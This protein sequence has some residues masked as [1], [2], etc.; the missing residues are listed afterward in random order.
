MHSGTEDVITADAAVTLDGLFRQ[1]LHRSPDRAAYRSYDKEAKQ[2]RDVTWA[3]TAAEVARWQESL[4]KEGLAPGDRVALSVRNCWEWVL[5]EQAA[6]G[7]GLVVVPLYTDDRPDN[8]AYILRD[9]AVKVLMVG[10]AG[11]WRRLAPAMQGIEQLRRVLIL[12]CERRPAPS[13]ADE[14]VICVREWLASGEYALRERHGPA[15]DLATIVYTSGTTGRPKGVMLSHHNILAIAHSALAS[16]DVYLE[17]VLLS[18]LPLSHS[19]ERTVGYYLPMMAGATVAYARSIQQLSDDLRQVR[20][21]MLIAV[22]RIF[23]RIY[24]RIQEQL[25]KKSPL[26]RSLFR[27][28]V[29]VGWKR[30]QM[31]QGRRMAGPSLA[32]WPLLDRMVARK[33]RERLGGRT[34][35]IVSGGAPLPAQVSRTFIGLGLPIVQ[36]YGM[37]E[38]SPVVSGNLLH[39]NDPASVGRPLRSVEVR[40]GANDELLVRGP[41]VMLGYWNNHAATAHTIDSDGWLHTGDRARIDDGRIYIIGRIKDILV[42]SNG[43]KV[44]PGDIEAAICSDP[45]FEQVM[46]VGEGKSYLGALLVLNPDLWIEFCEHPALDPFAPASLADDRVHRKLL[47]RI[48]D[49]MHDFP[50]Y[51]KVRRVRVSLDPWSVEDGLLTPTLKVRRNAVAERFS[52]QIEALYA[53][54]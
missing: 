18:F 37:T 9:A 31:Q 13:P 15:D 5:F 38:T 43:E 40:I 52:Q 11:L 42:L 45:L 16:Y 44:P 53:D 54:D 41:G 26:A 47:L 1:R 46:V 4:A 6:L 49:L 17:D 2:W 25:A 39:D 51:A 36:G 28:T 48:R 12:D 7:L 21:T 20:P 50:G 29:A 3:Q 22:P 24:S 19:Y 10:D 8:V 33:I 35:L 32:M 27:T 14:R 23:E 30:F 34:R